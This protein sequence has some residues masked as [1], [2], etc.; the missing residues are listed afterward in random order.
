MPVCAVN[1]MPKGEYSNLF[2]GAAF[3]RK[4]FLS[5]T[6]LPVKNSYLLTFSDG[7]AEILAICLS[8]SF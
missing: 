8:K 4:S 2:I 3:S 6:Y 1:L 7:K 5:K